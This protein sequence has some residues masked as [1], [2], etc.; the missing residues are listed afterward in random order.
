MIVVVARVKT[1][2]AKRDELMRVALTNVAASRGDA[3]CISYTFYEDTQVPNHFV[4]V[5]E[6]ESQEALQAHFATP[7]IAEFMGA[8]PATLVAP[9][10]IQFHTIASTQNL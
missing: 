8:I 10:D 2:A 4:F 9:P 7:H 6:W 5:E 1:D 3:G